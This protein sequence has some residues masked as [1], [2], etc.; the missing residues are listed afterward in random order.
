V[1]AYR[2]RILGLLGD[3]PV[4]DVLQATPARIEAL[5]A[6]LGTAGLARPWA[7]GKWTGRE[8][9]AHLADAEL[10]TG[11]RFRQ[12]V[13]EPHHVIQPFDQDRWASRYGALDGATAARA[14][15]ALRPWNLE[16]VRTFSESD[17]ARPLWHPER[18][19][20]SLGTLVRML[21][22]HDLNHLAQ[23]EQIPGYSE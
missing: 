16:L 5:V 18:G 17:L 11:F 8:I 20:E 22:G 1:S 15:C 21:G 6:R 23:L 13:A 12:A 3:R 10:A 4:L 9:L 2:E 19:M 14:F 7:P